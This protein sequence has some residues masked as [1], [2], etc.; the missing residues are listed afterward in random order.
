MTQ[1]VSAPSGKGGEMGR[2]D[3]GAADEELRAKLD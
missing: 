2:G 3:K 1:T